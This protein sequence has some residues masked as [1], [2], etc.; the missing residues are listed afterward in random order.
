MGKG[1]PPQEAWQKPP[2]GAE[3]LVTQPKMEDPPCVNITPCF[4]TSG[5]LLSWWPWTRP[6]P[7]RSPLKDAPGVKEVDFISRTTSG[8]PVGDPAVFPASL[9]FN[10]ATAVTWTDAADGWLHHPSASLGGGSTSRRCSCWGAR[11]PMDWPSS[12][13][14]DYMTWPEWV[15]GHWSGGESG[16]WRY[17][18]WLHSGVGARNCCRRRSPRR[19]CRSPWCRGSGERP[20][21]TDWLGP[22]GSSCPSRRPQHQSQ[23]LWSK[24]HIVPIFNRMQRRT[25]A[26]DRNR[27]QYRQVLQ[28]SRSEPRRATMN[29]LTRSKRL[30]GRHRLGSARGHIG[31]GP[32]NRQ[33]QPRTGCLLLPGGRSVGI[34]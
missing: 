13:P 21:V 32:K 30:M 4:R 2:R 1:K 9:P 27:R 25:V 26:L 28:T 6:S 31:G 33:N 17:S 16:G 10:S 8:N 24:S 18:R 5:S 3:L 14:P 20:C 23:S 7:G 19:H 29:D 12:E 15:F 34:W 11:R 22:F